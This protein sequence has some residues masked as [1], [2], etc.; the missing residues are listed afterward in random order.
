MLQKQKISFVGFVDDSGN[1][2]QQQKEMTYL[3]LF[4]SMDP[5]TGEEERRFEI[6]DGRYW[7][8]DRIMGAQNRYQYGLV[9]MFKSQLIS[10]KVT[11]FLTNSISFYTFVRYCI[12]K[13]VPV[14]DDGDGNVMSKEEFNDFIM[15]EYYED[16]VDMGIFDEEDLERYY[17]ADFHHENYVPRE[18]VESEN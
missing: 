15:S 12:D 7:V 9:N 3:L 6:V 17:Q 13:G 1:E 8:C 16:M 14:G 10:E 11:S 2:I 5:E 4:F 18:Q